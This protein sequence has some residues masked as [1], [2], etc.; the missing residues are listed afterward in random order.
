V[1]VQQVET[2][3][4]QPVANTYLNRI[5]RAVLVI[6]VSLFPAAAT[7][8]LFSWLHADLTQFLPLGWNDQTW[9]W[10]QVSTYSEVGFDGGY[11]VVNEMPAAANFSHFSSWGP[12]YPMMLGTIAR[13]TGW[14]PYTGIILNLV[15]LTGTIG[16]FLTFI[17]FSR[18]QIL[19]TGLVLLTLTPI[20]MY[21]PTISQET[22]HQSAAFLVAGIFYVLLTQQNPPRYLRWLAVLL[23][24]F[25]SVVRFS[26]VIFFLPLFLIGASQPGKRRLVTALFKAGL[27]AVPVYLLIGYISAPGGNFLFTILGAITTAPL[28]AIGN[29]LLLMIE[30]FYRFLFPFDEK[31]L[32]TA[33]FVQAMQFVLLLGTLIVFWI[34]RRRV[35]HRASAA[36][37]GADMLFHLYNLTII[38]FLALLFYR[39][40]GYY[41]IFAIHLLVTVLLLIGF[42]HY[43]LVGTF[44]I[45]GLIGLPVSLNHYQRQHAILF[46]QDRAALQLETIRATFEQHLI[47]DPDAVN[48]WC[49]TVLVP[50]RFLNYHVLAIPPRIGISFLWFGDVEYPL[51][52]H[53]LFFDQATYQERKD[54]LR[55]EPLAS[56]PEGVLYNNIDSGCPDQ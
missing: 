52:S 10:H 19:L 8:L 24:I 33:D 55:V 48:S 21:L 56:L 40:N 18:T 14:E 47:Y 51:K 3:N 22:F 5:P 43:R 54:Q 25:L 6:I 12:V 32:P 4:S 2:A 29:L 34:Q 38:F 17:P 35:P 45:V 37:L 23:L 49:N 36:R 41:R 20:L 44:I 11:Y 15:L 42:K 1:S 27:I 28:K 26:W 30:N 46:H 39:W 13:L 50:T 16:L 9:M 7:L 31:N 53:Y